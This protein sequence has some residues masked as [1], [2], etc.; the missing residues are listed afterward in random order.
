MPDPGAQRAAA[1]AEQQRMEQAE[2]AR[3]QELQAAE[4]KQQQQEENAR[5]VR[6]RQKPLGSEGFVAY[7]SSQGL[8][9]QQVTVSQWTI[10]RNTAGVFS[11][12]VRPWL[13]PHVQVCSPSRKL[14]LRA[15]RVFFDLKGR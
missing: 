10:H 6:L 2:A 3:L 4:A 13:V 8:L 12:H 9:G 14:L 5:Q 7:S 1:A 11:L 15:A